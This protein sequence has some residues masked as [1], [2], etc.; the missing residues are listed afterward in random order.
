MQQFTTHTF[1]VFVSS[2]HVRCQTVGHQY[3]NAQLAVKLVDDFVAVKHM[4]RSLNMCVVLWRLYYIVHTLV[5]ATRTF[6]LN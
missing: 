2:N 4:W 3:N 6:L 1:G 5:S